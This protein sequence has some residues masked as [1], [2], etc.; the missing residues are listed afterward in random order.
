MIN[1]PSEERSRLMRGIRFRDTGLELEFRRALWA[2]GLRGYRKNVCGLPGT[3]DVVFG[4]AKL[5]IFVH[6]CFWHGCPRC[7]RNTPRT[8]TAFWVEKLGKNV[9]RDERQRLALE[10]GGYKVLTFWECDL[11]KR[12]E[13]VIAQV[14]AALASPD[15]FRQTDPSG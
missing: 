12:R 1:A 9:E 10:Q 7:A 5:A 3:P 13:E 8:N 11:R 4:R 6:G 2:A 15:D 14:A